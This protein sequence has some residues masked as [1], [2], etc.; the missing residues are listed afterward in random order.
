MQSWIKVASLVHSYVLQCRSLFLY[1]THHF[2]QHP[3]IE[4]VI[5][6]TPSSLIHIFVFPAI[7]IHLSSLCIRYIS[8]IL[9]YSFIPYFEATPFSLLSPEPRV[10]EPAARAGRGMA[11]SATFANYLCT[12]ENYTVVQTV[13]YTTYSD[14]YKCVPLPKLLGAPALYRGLT[15]SIIHIIISGPSVFD[16]TQLE[17]TVSSQQ[18]IILLIHNHLM[19]YSHGRCT[20]KIIC[21]PLYFICFFVYISSSVSILQL[22]LTF[23]EET[24]S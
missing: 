18:P 7:N 23:K 19:D 21:F 2:S 9:L 13:S 5:L 15:D 24:V 6:F 14:F 16:C 20:M 12:K 22:L 10:F 8:F 11:P 1:N 4:F 3:S 17:T